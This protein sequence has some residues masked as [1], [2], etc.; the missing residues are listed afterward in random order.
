MIGYVGYELLEGLN[1][2]NV[3]ALSSVRQMYEVT[4]VMDHKNGLP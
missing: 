4:K 1:I 3:F 2:G